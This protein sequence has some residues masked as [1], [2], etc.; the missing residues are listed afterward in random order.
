MAF[1]D[2]A[3]A[4]YGSGTYGSASY[5]I[6]A[7]TVAVTGVSGTAL[8]RTLHINAFEVDITEPLYGPNALTGSI[9]TLEF[10]NTVTLTGVAGTA[11]VGTVSPNVAVNVTS[12]DIFAVLNLVTVHVSEKLDSVS[13]T[14]TINSAGLIIRSI[15]RVPVTSPAMT[16]SVTAPEPRVDE[17]I[18]IGVQGTTALGS[19]QVNIIEKLASVSATGSIGSLEHSNTVTLTGVEGVGQIGEVEDQPLERIATGVQATGAIG[20]LAFSN[21]FTVTGVQGTFGIGSVTAT[22]VTFTFVAADYDRRRV[23]YVPRNDTA[24]E[25]RMAA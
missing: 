17:T 16:G 19:I 14:G 8:T 24:A 11:Q 23:A 1:Y 20:T 2:S 7:P 10:A 21:A 6:V 9:G 12:A 25:R 22:G 5:G 18:T 15:N 4:I 13:A 3:D